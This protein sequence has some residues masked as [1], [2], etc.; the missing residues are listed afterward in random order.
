MSIRQS[1]TTQ[2]NYPLKSLQNISAQTLKPSHKSIH[3]NAIL[4]ALIW[5]ILIAVFVW[6]SVQ[7]ERRQ[8]ISL[9]ENEARA[10]FNKDQA[11]RF[12]ATSH[13]GV[14]VPVSEKTQPNP[15]L[16]HI[17]ER[18]LITPS[19]K[20]LTLM[21]PAF[22]VRQLMTEYE[23]LYGV[24]GRITG[25]K[26]LNQLNDPDPWEQQALIAFERG[27]QEVKE[28]SEIEDLPL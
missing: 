1:P 11:F 4:A 3:Q 27:A 8:M 25:L 9:V 18:D 21:N 23:K 7:A 17:I 12:W 24:K 28:Y 26:V 16:S 6:W 19:G 13:G 20:K 5:T 2:H 15:N 14:Y 22:M 10:H